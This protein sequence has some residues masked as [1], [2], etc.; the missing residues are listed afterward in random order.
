MP[1][2]WRRRNKRWFG[3]RYKRRYP[4]YRQKRRK[5]IYRRRKYRRPT[6]RRRR[7]R[8]KVRRKKPTLIVRQWQPDS[9]VLCK[10]KGFE[11]LIWGAQGTQFQ[12]STYNMYD[13]T[14]TR[15]PG[16][17]GFAVQLYSLEY[18]YDQWKL[19]NNIWTKTNQLKDL[20]RYLKSIFTF[21]RHPTIDFVIVYNRQPPFELDKLSYMNYHPYMLLQRKHKIILPS[22]ATNPRGK[23]K[24]RKVIKPPKQMLSKWFFQQQFSKYD[25]LELSAAAISLRY[26]RIGCCNE[27]RMLTLYCINTKFF[28]DTDWAQTPIHSIGGY[29]KPYQQI[30]SEL[31]FYSQYDKDGYDINQFIINTHGR[32]P[33]ETPYMRS[34]SMEGGWFSKKVLA[35]YNIKNGS[36]PYAPLQMVL[37]RYNPALDDGDGNIVY[38]QSIITGHWQIPQVTPDFVIKNQPLWLAFWG[39]YDF[40]SH[41]KGS[42][43]FTAHMFVVQSKYIKFEQT[44]TPNQF[45]AFIDQ[46]FINGKWPWDS[47]IYYSE[48]KLWYPT[49]DWQLKTIN[50]ICSSGPYVPK[51][52]NQNLS[53]WELPISYSFHFKWGGPQIQNEPVEDP[54]NK[55]KYDVPDTIKQRVQVLDP[56]KNIAATM[57][58]QWDYRRGCLTSTAIK[59]MQQNLPTDSSLEYDSDTEPP[60]KKKRI[61]PV[62]HNPQEETEKFHNCLL[63]LCEESTCQEPQTQENILQL[64]QQQQQQ[65]Q[66]LKH[67]LLI[68][69]KDLKAKQR[70]LQ[71]QTGVLE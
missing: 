61:L 12:C 28:Q 41:T 40:L 6:R 43:I 58:H 15:Y 70:L 3:R 47:P 60:K 64:I 20:C 38:L 49:C 68:L 2:W 56:S 22:L 8:R 69:I 67:N 19:R 4:T 5:R 63:S 34:I 48:K 7:R 45:W 44:E 1:F 65:Q 24:K 52:D 57:F 23:S 55:N 46:D 13:Y 33:D 30:P 18:L 31:K 54:G 50:A 53:T 16:G 21:Y 10:I 29:Y 9:I 62:L 42:A 17:G 11:S 27:N 37:G 25:L 32:P 66:K 14:R 36:Q 51:L 26:P 35:A 59:R 71:L 39:Y